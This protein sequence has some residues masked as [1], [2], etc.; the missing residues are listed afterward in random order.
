MGADKDPHIGNTNS[1]I[2]NSG[3]AV[4]SEDTTY[5]IKPMPGGEDGNIYKTTGQQGIE[6]AVMVSDM[7]AISLSVSGD[8]IY[9]INNIK[10]DSGEVSHSALMRVKSDGSGTQ[11]VYKNESAP[12]ICLYYIYGERIYYS[13]V[14]SVGEQ[15]SDS[16]IF[17]MK[18][19]GSDVRTLARQSGFFVMLAV[20][21]KRIYFYDRDNYNIFRMRLSG[22]GKKQIGS[23]NDIETNPEIF[24]VTYHDGDLYYFCTLLNNA[25]GEFE[26]RFYRYNIETMELQRLQSDILSFNISDGWIY[27]GKFNRQNEFD[28]AHG[29]YKARLDDPDTEMLVNNSYPHITSQIIN[30]AGDMLYILQSSDN[31]ALL[32]YSVSTDGKTFETIYKE[33]HGGSVAIG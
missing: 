9:F 32:F 24:N 6:D 14:Y 13:V 7:S 21:N 12:R 19:D 18:L 15:G 16:H 10:D 25:K 2:I 28:G 29:L 5:F 8:Y 22:S 30:K 31:Y 26:N 27:Y 23:L 20:E 17:S 4:Q 11:L 1:N 3:F 33:S